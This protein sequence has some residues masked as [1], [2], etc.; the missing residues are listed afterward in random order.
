M[1]PLGRL[2]GMRLDPEIIIINWTY[3]LD[4]EEML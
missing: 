3:Y 1:E 4:C 2:T